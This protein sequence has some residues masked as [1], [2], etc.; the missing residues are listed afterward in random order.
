MSRLSAAAIELFED[1]I[2]QQVEDKAIPSISYG[3]VDC[4][5]L[6]VAGHIQRHNR[7]FAMGDDTCFRIGSI[8]K[9]F[10][11]LSIMQLAE[12]GLVDLDVDVS[13]YLPG[14]KPLNPFAGREGGSH[15]AQIS[16]RKLMSHTAGLVREPKSG[17]YLDAR[18][19]PLAD[20]VAELATSTLKQDPSLGQMHYSNAGIAVA[21]RVIET[22]TRR[23][24][25]EY[26][27]E[28]ILKPLGMNQTSSG[29]APGIAERLA[30]AD[31]WTL[32]GDSP[33]PVFDLGGPPAGNI[34]S[35]VGDMARY[36]QC[37]L[38]GGFAPDGRTIASPASLRE[39]WVPVGKRASGE[40]VANTY[41]LCFGVGDVDG[42]TSV[43]HG[44]AVYGYSSQMIL[45]PAAG[46]GVLIFSTLDFSNQI[47]ARLGVEGLRIALAERRMGTLPVRP[48]SLPPVAADQL[49]A[50]PG[51]YRHDTS[52]EV[53]EVK[54]KAGKLFLMGEGVP[55]QIRPVAG[56]DFTIDGRI[57]GHGA[58]YP[59][60]NLS[61]PAPGALVWKGVN[62]TRIDA[63]PAEAVPAEIAPHLGE[64]GPDFNIT[65]LSY[66]HGELKCLI[67]YFCTH[68]CE[69]V[70]AGRFRMHGL[71]YEEEIL[72]IDAIDDHGRRGIR[73]GPMFLERRHAP[74]A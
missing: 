39:M 65:Y 34:Y 20:T 28:N 36:A 58:E 4:D 56:S 55:L 61:F 7:G 49:V 43:G 10:T 3:L 29:L 15:G 5:G 33:A 74:A 25:A 45:L 17:H 73:V 22:L 9:T 60:M 66:S 2:R 62:W 54:A 69:P 51:H 21:G 38:R 30:P 31:M 24:Y 27:T 40:R 68:S 59:H 57:Y 8:T 71:L 35:T 23:S 14:F 37:L 18:R 63:L 16:L 46:V 44:G 12:K 41:G 53:V 26:V 52:G 64:Y 70:E 72:E 1:L 32:E 42:W 13:E 50:L 6:M 19:P 11:A 47:G 67:E 48:Q